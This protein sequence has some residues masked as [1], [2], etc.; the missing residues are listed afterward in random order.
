NAGK[1]SKLGELIGKC[2]IESVTKAIGKQV[3]ITNNSQSNFWLYYGKNQPYSSG[4]KNN[5]SEIFLKNCFYFFGNSVK[6]LTYLPI[7]FTI[8]PSDIS[9]YI[10]EVL[11]LF[12]GGKE[13]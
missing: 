4:R 12:R 13:L 5:F 11:I 2:V 10:K 7:M 9:S 3:W 6:T 1:H 8:N